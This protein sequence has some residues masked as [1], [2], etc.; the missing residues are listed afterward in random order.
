MKV[1]GT[2]DIELLLRRHLEYHE[3]VGQGIIKQIYLRIA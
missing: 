2:I 3:E 1:L